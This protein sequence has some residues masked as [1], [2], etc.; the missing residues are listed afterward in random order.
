MKTILRS[1]VIQTVSFAW[2][3]NLFHFKTLDIILEDK[4]KIVTRAFHLC[5]TRSIKHGQITHVWPRLAF[6]TRIFSL[7]PN[8]H[9]FSKRNRNFSLVL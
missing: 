4:L 6:L 3:I 1:L 5:A 9:Q 8:F 7:P 2:N